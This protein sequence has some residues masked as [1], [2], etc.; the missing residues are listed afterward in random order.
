M[1]RSRFILLW[2]VT[3]TILTVAACAFGYF[4]WPTR[5]QYAKLTEKGN[6]RPVRIGRIS[7]R[8][9]ILCGSGWEPVNEE[10]VYL[11][12]H[13]LAKLR[14][15]AQ[16][17][18]FQS[19]PSIELYNGSAFTVTHLTVRLQFYAQGKFIVRAYVVESSGGVKAGTH[20]RFVLDVGPT[21]AKRRVL[22]CSLSQ[23]RG[24]HDPSAPDLRVP[25]LGDTELSTADLDELIRLSRGL[26]YSELSTAEFDELIRRAEALGMG[27]E[28][29]ASEPTVPRVNLDELIRQS[30]AL[31]KVPSAT[32]KAKHGADDEK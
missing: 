28:L 32:E 23:A 17:K 5:Y 14:V 11:P 25:I 12:K 9:E 4:I 16:W 31:D 13:E 10:S 29:P 30:E 20:R 2:F 7:G 18:N 6:T 1:P 27:K 21:F 8:T 22:R 15:S 3:L 24:I 26:D 19:G